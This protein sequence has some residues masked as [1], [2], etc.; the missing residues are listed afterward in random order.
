MFREASNADSTDAATTIELSS[1][2]VPPTLVAP[3]PSVT[4][5]LPNPRRQDFRFGSNKQTPL[6]VLIYKPSTY[7]FDALFTSRPQKDTNRERSFLSN[8]RYIMRFSNVDM[9][10]ICRDCRSLLARVEKAAKSFT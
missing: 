2:V 3:E 10:R 1:T 6:R 8:H 7:S 4:K 5:N 9:S